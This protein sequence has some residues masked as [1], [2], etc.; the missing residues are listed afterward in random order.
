MHHYKEGLKQAKNV[1]DVFE[2]VKDA[3]M[4]T[5]GDSRAGLNL[6]LMEMGNG[7]AN[8]LGAFYPVGSNVIVMNKTPL[9][10]IMETEPALM[11]PYLFHVLLHEY[12]H[13]LGFIDERSC[14]ILTYNICKKLFGKNHITAEMSKDITQFMPYIAYPGG[15][16]QLDR[17][18]NDIKIIEDFDRENE[19]YIG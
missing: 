8:W 17:D 16:P 13:S 15:F 5:I 6:G 3:V 19:V 11:K 1:S 4:E 10:R 18:I 7:N 12:L 14:R 9:R 2:L